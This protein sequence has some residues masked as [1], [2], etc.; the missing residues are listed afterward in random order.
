M[1]KFCKTPNCEASTMALQGFENSLCDD[2]WEKANI[3]LNIVTCGMCSG[4]FAHTVAI[5]EL[6]CP[7]CSFNDDISSFPDYFYMPQHNNSLFTINGETKEVN[8]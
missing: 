3:T 5:N 7:Y 2:C 4:I 1:A 8:I 6:T